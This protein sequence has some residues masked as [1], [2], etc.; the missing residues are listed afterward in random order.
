[1]PLPQLSQISRLCQP[2]AEA[3]ILFLLFCCL[4]QGLLVS[5]LAAE[6]ELD[7]AQKTRPEF[8]LSGWVFH[9]YGYLSGASLRAVPK[10]FCIEMG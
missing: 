1:M 5:S 3:L 4:R 10:R 7:D 9:F 8:S 6:N 2:R